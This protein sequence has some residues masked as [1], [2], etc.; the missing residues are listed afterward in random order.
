MPIANCFIKKELLKKPNKYQL[1]EDWVSSINVDVEDIT[2]NLIAAF[3][4]LGNNYKIMVQLYLPSL[5]TENNIKNIQVQL[6]RV[7]K[8]FFEVKEK[9]IFILTNIIKSGH[10]VENGQIIRWE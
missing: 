8:N 6:I 9:D 4:Q 5:W 1:V 3:E 7:L 2:L 10:V